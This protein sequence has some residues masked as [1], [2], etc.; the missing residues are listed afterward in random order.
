VIGRL[1]LS[2][3][4]FR[5]VFCQLEVLRH[6]LPASI[7][8]TLDQL[9][10]SLDE[11]YVRVLSQIS[12]ANQAHAHRMLQCL[13]VAVRPLRV[14]ELAEMLAFEFDAAQGGIPK[15]R[16]AWRLDDQ[17]QAVLS[18]CSSLV[19]IVDDDTDWY[20]LQH[21]RRQVV[22]FSHFSVKEFLSSNRLTSSIS[23]YRIRPV[24]A[25]TTLTQACLGFLLQDDHIDKKSIKG[26]P[27]AEYAAH[28][29]VEHAQFKDV[30]SRVKDGMETLFDPD[31]SYFA[32]WIGIH[33]IDKVN[34]PSLLAPP[35]VRPMPQRPFLD[36]ESDSESETSPNPKANILNP[37]YYSVL[38]GFYDLA[39]HL[40][41]KFPH[42]V[43]AFYGRYEFP[44]FAA[45]SEDHL[46]VGRL[47]LEH[48]ANV[49]AQET[50]GKT[51]LLKVFSQ[52]HR[53]LVDIVALLLKHG[54]DV[55]IQDRHLI[56]A[57]HLAEHHGELDVARMLLK[58]K[59]DVNSRDYDG[60]TALHILSEHRFGIHNQ[61]DILNHARLLLKYGADM[62]RQNSRNQTPLHV[63]MGSER[64]TLARIL[65]EHGANAQAEDSYGTTP[66]HLLSAS[67]IRNG[68]SL[69]LVWLLLGRGAEV[70][71]RDKDKQTPLHL[72]MRVDW[73]K[74]A[75]ILLDRGAD[76]NAEDIHGM[77]PLLLLSASQIHDDDA[78]DLVWPL[79][80]HGAELNKR[81]KD[82]QSPLHLAMVTDW[83]Q[84]A[85]VLLDRGADAGTE[86]VHGKTPLHIL[87]ASR[88]HDS[89]TLDIVSLLLGHGAVV[90]R[91]DK[92]KQTPLHLAI[93][94]NWFQLAR[95]L[96]DQ[97]ADAKAEYDNGTT[98]LH[99]LSASQIHDSDALDLALLLLDHGAEV[100]SRD[101][102]K[103]TPL[104]LAM[105]E[106]WF[107]LARILLDHGADANTEDIHGTTPLH[108]LS[109]SRLH[110][111]DILDLVWPLLGHGAV[112][113]IADKDK[114]T[115]LLLA[116]GGDWFELARILLEHGADAD[117]DND[118][119]ATPLHLLSISQ[120]HDE[121]DAL[122]L[123][124]LLLGH[125]AVVNKRDKI[126][127]TP[128]LLAMGRGWFNLARILLEHGA[129]ANAEDNNGKTPLHMLSEFQ[130][131]DKSDSPSQLPLYHVADNNPQDAN[132][133][134]PF[135]SQSNFGPV[136]IAQA[137]LD[138]GA[139]V[140]AGN[141]MD[142]TSLYRGLEGNIIF[143]AIDNAQRLTR[144]FRRHTRTKYVP[145]PDTAT[146]GVI[147]REARY[148]TVTARPWCNCQFGRQVWPDPIAPSG[149]RRR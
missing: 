139:N 102:N 73:F 25:H 146:L 84:L 10:Q 36:S 61:D 46:E 45:L 47:L 138:H 39:K 42:Y 121:G 143:H 32:A 96:L 80:E 77:T 76:A 31:K 107:Q 112:V 104:H 28:H 98:P 15:Y 136:Q 114:Q 115:P 64:F 3:Y 71:R 4:R 18:T 108:L 86:D 49:D 117:V 78:L 134:T 62:N 101:K 17:T 99:L 147:V 57:L 67:R 119:G 90:N 14:E 79:L 97:G 145:P 35:G 135:R 26:F 56:S 51:I 43:N 94:G 126:N 103:K 50:T 23:R 140:N 60:R 83:F 105:E 130:I 123:L 13:L 24:P 6:C 89:D 5:W 70:N 125:G 116:I 27:L 59:A 20:L 48:G 129:D 33:D 37:L 2:L 11:T 144:P 93:G 66:L 109:A 1:T 8:Q 120:T 40:V 88:L 53:S 113:N 124:W 30:A 106:Y 85:R 75:R 118:K 55:N 127:Q 72:S 111:N 58:H 142:E 63:A 41:V 82:K 110:D 149:R 137:L 128:L 133:M 69:D 29:W 95:V 7:R 81:N 141:N 16:A 54:A 21:R 52:P 100:N 122:D 91:R 74:L 68:D 34:Y 132:P 19:T 12:Q 131:Y 22:Q 38:C 87:S 148:R 92:D 65:I 9:P 44:L